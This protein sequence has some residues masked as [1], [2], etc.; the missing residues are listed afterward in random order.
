MNTTLLLIILASTA[1]IAMFLASVLYMR[2][3]SKELLTA[4]DKISIL[5]N[6]VMSIKHDAKNYGEKI[7]KLNYDHYDDLK[8]RY[9]KLDLSVKDV[10]QKV[11]NVEMSFKKFTAR[12][13][14]TLNKLLE[15][16]NNLP[17][18]TEQTELPLD[19]NTI[20]LNADNL[21]PYN[22]Q[23]VQQTKRRKFGQ[24]P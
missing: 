3:Q 1:N 21:S 20:P 24:M 6:D 5:N 12:W 14:R 18:E 13:A 7:D 17:A 10:E 23:A 2:A 15:Q 11:E 22:N 8:K 16:A 19:N 9:L 4:Q